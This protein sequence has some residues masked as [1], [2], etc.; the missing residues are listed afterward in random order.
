MDTYEIKTK[1]KLLNMLK[2]YGS[3]HAKDFIEL[4]H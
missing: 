1:L 4:S 3:S 2:S